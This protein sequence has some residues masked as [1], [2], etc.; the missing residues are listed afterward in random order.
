M[1]ANHTLII[2]RLRV[3]K[4]EI[5]DGEFFLMR[6]QKLYHK[7]NPTFVEIEEMEAIAS[8]FHALCERKR[9]DRKYGADTRA[10]LAKIFPGWVGLQ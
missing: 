6:L 1:T 8:W 10:E 2:K 5:K 4:D 7:D 9:G 3:E